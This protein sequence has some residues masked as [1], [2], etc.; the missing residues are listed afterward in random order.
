VTGP[1]PAH[2]RAPLRALGVDATAAEVVPALN[3]AGCES[4]VL[5]GPTFQREL[6]EVGST[7]PYDDLDLLVSPRDMDVAGAVLERAGFTLALDHRDHSTLAEPHAQEWQRPTGARVD[8]HWKLPGVGARASDA[9]VVLEARSVPFRLGVTSARGLD[10]VGIALLVA[11][12]AA[13]HDASLPK[14]RNDL[15]RAVERFD[16]EI[17]GKAA[18]LA[19]RLDAREAFVAGLRLDRSGAAVCDTLRLREAPSAHRSLMTSG[20]PPGAFGLLA[21][22]EARRGRLRATRDALLP[23]P[24]FMRFVYPLARRGRG[25]LVLAHCLRL[26]V[27]ARSFP[28]ALR[29]VRR[30]RRAT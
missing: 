13:H 1:L 14:P 27:R 2:L 26:L 9:W 12:H 22:T 29:A 3:L 25:G 6:Y 17:W 28:A 5:K 10:R 20:P 23:P 16:L 11:L 24:E 30:A 19:E 21:I 4:I 8:L 7:R 15:A 18:L